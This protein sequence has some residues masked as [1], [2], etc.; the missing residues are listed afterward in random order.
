MLL[1]PT[2]VRLPTVK[3][4]NLFIK[5]KIFSLR[6]SKFILNCLF[7]HYNLNIHSSTYKLGKNLRSKKN[8][9][10]PQ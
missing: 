1:I 7:L 10:S 6:I 5:K 3:Q 4:P 8:K 9:R 2:V